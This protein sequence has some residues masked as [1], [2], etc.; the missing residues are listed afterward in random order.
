M[1]LNSEQT[2]SLDLSLFSGKVSG[3]AAG[4]LPAGASPDC[5]DV[6]F[7][8]Q[9]V[10]TRP[11]IIYALENSISSS[12]Y[13]LGAVDVMSHDA[14]S[15][16]DGLKYIMALDSAGNINQYNVLEGTNSVLG[17]VEP[18]SRFCAT[19]AFSK[20]FMAFFDGHESAN[21]SD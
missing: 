5:A 14:Y 13:G 16:P 1:A 21:F 12:S 11:A 20:F 19:Q 18:G 7:L 3:I 17:V 15:A 2:F 6:F 4:N 9:Q 10:A 8:P